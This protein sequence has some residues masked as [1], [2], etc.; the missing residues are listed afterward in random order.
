MRTLFHNQGKGQ[1]VAE[2]TAMQI[3]VYR[4]ER[5]LN[6]FSLSRAA[7]VSSRSH[8]PVYASAVKFGRRNPRVRIQFDAEFSVVTRGLIWRV[9]KHSAAEKCVHTLSHTHN[10]AIQT[11]TKRMEGSKK[12]TLMF[13][14]CYRRN[15]VIYTEL[16]AGF[17]LSLSWRVQTFTNTWFF[18]A[19]DRD[20]L[21]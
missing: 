11:T 10:R 18:C 3:W 20:A 13:S 19:F 15:L 12:Q 9:H 7:S 14:G 16:N 4:L 1:G 21:R 6:F 2:E 8:S 17:D 5:K